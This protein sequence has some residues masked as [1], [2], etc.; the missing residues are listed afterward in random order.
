MPP[1]ISIQNLTYRYP[2]GAALAAA[3][4]EAVTLTIE[5]GEFV[6]V[7][8]SNGSGK[9]TLAKHLNALLIPTEGVVLVDGLNTRDP[10]RV[11]D[12][13][14]RVGMVFQ[15]PDNQLVATIVE[16]DVAFGPENLGVPPSEIVSRVADALRSVDMLA[17]RQHEPH[18]LSGGQ[19][20]RVAI[21]GILAMHPQCLVLDEA[22]TM[23]DPAGQREVMETIA[24]LNRDG[25]TIIHITHNMEEAAA[26]RRVIALHGGRVALDGSPEEVFARSEDLA[27]LRLAVPSIR[28]LAE[29][30]AHAGV[31]IPPRT[32]T[33]DQLED[34][35]VGLARQRVDERPVDG[36]H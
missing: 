25:I 27:R 35:L 17:Y 26:C 28:A 13:R 1:L 2:T 29:R 4:L 18:L 9:S 6:A 10:A 5:R 23:L 12:I 8:G 15:N 14:Q 30:L 16:E 7:V 36:P 3:A 33:V 22:T 11:W 34:T 32:L 24:R 21:A 20:Q 19:K 31:P